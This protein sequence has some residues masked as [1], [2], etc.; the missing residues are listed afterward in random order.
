M[1][2]E[3][4]LVPDKL[5]FPLMY[6][7]EDDARRA[8]LVPGSHRVP[9]RLRL[10][11]NFPAA[12]LLHAEIQKACIFMPKDESGLYYMECAALRMQTGHEPK[13]ISSLSEVPGVSS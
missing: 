6:R 5:P 9:Q 3:P 13:L 7:V 11:F 4:N 12:M 8:I 10:W 2:D 1:T